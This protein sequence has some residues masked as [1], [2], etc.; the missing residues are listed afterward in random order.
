MKTSE[1]IDL[2]SKA[3]VAAQKEIGAAVK[4]SENPFFKS[5]YAD[6][7]SVIEAVKEPLNNHGLAYIQL[8][9]SDE[10]DI[11][12][13]IILHESGQFIGTE[14][15]VYCGKPNDPQ[16]FGTGITYAK[17]Y[18]LQ[19]ALGLPTEDD[20]GN[21]ASKMPSAKPVELTEE[22]LEFIAKVKIVAEENLDGSGIDGPKLRDYMVSSSQRTKKPIPTD[23][24]MVSVI[25]EFILNN[26]N[27][28]N[29]IKESA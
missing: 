5:K 17:R 6:L 12:E 26:E 3:L 25:A 23:E 13:T 20:D 11:V 27:V 22:Q 24:K 18:A 29:S 7:S 4:G 9:Q 15:R 14:T 21:A 16:A 19:A 2:V 10:K 28:L 8:V 1:K